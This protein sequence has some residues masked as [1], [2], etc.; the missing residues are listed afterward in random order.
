MAKRFFHYETIGEG[1]PY[2]TR[3]LLGRLRLHI[4]HRGDGDADPHNH[5]WS[6]TTFPLT[7]YVEE[8]THLA[9]DGTIRRTTEVVRAWRFHR[10]DAAHLHRVL[11]PL[12]GNRLWPGKIVTL[13]L[14]GRS[15]HRWGFLKTRAGQS[16]WQSWPEYRD[17]GRFAPCA[18][19]GDAPPV[20]DQSEI[21]QSKASSFG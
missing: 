18:P 5:P 20:E 3:L 19:T 11:G 7:G 10:R 17:G 1:S 12:P 21:A 16:C 2:M 8:V 15:D 6:F 9:A 13:V 4:F 14:R